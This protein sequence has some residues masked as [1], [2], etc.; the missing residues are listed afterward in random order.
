MVHLHIVFICKNSMKNSFV[1]PLLK[2]F[3]KNR[4]MLITFDGYRKNYP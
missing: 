1:K 4:M 3:P 2:I